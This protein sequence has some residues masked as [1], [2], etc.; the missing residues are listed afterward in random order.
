M[1]DQ[2]QSPI[3]S[4]QENQSNLNQETQTQSPPS[5]TNLITGTESVEFSAVQVIP[6]APKP[7]TVSVTQTNS[8]KTFD[9][10]EVTGIVDADRVL[11][12][13][14][15]AHQTGIQRLMEY[16]EKMHPSRPIEDNEGAKMQAALF[17]IIQ[18]TINREEVYFKQIFAAIL[19]I[20]THHKSGAFKEIN[21]FRF[22][23]NVTLNEVERKAF[24]NLLNMIKL[25]G[26]KESRTVALKQIDMS[27]ALRYGLT[28]NGRQRVLNFFNVSK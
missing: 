2:T 17:R 3:S 25:L 5:L 28:D 26:P 27:K 13:V 9:W 10:P 22:M 14:P 11:K 7:P 23:D 16:A 15:T 18:N 21:V 4:D 12:N 6:S 8:L 19:A 20:F 1:S 24:T